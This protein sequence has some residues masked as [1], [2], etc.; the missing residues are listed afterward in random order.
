MDY[1][2][3][4]GHAYNHSPGRTTKSRVRDALSTIGVSI[5]GGAIT[6]AGASFFLLWCRIFLFVQ[7]GVMM[8]S[9]TVTAFVYTL[10]CLSACLAIIGPVKKCVCLRFRPASSTIRPE[11]IPAATATDVSSQDQNS[12]STERVPRQGSDQFTYDAVYPEPG[13]GQ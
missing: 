1:S 7:L 2:L 11:D 5:F 8:L 3:H 6:T 12:Y 10:A 9:N 4:L 13:E